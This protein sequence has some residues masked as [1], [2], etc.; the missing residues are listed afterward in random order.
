MTQTPSPVASSS[1][2][3]FSL[4][5]LCVTRSGTRPCA[6]K[7]SSTSTNGSC[8]SA[9]SISAFTPAA[10]LQASCSIA[11]RRA[12][13]RPPAGG[14]VRG[15]LLNRPPQRVE[16]AAGVVEV[17]NR[18]AQARWGQVSE[19]L[20]KL[21]KCPGSLECLPGLFDLVV[22]LRPFDEQVAPPLVPF[23]VRI[24]AFAVERRYQ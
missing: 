21:A 22:A 18:I 7:S 17:G 11:R 24:P 5:S 20:L 13:Q 8:R 19:L 9:N 3:L 2:T 1:I 16:A 6:C 23:G 15:I 4:Q 14:A 10:R 12:S